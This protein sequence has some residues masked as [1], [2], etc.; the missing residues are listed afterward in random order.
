M[1]RQRQQAP[2]GSP[3]HYERHRPEQTA[4][5]LLVPLTAQPELVTALLTLVQRV[6]T[7]RLLHP[8]VWDWLH[9]S[10]PGI[11]LVD[12]RR[13]CNVKNVRMV[14]TM[15]AL[16]A[17]SFAQAATS[18]FDTGT[19]GWTAVGD[20]AAPVTWSATGGNPGGH[21]FI[22]DQVIGGVTYFDA[23]ID[24]RGDK[25]AAFGTNLTFDLMQVY[26]GGSNQ[27]DD[28]DVVIEGGGLAI[29]YDT[30][31]N[32]PNGAWASYAVPLSAG[33]WRLNSLSGAVATNQQ[34]LTVLS[35]VTLLRIRAEFQTGA[36]TGRLDNVSLVPEPGSALLL[37]GGLAA[38]LCLRRARRSE[39]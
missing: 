10:R 14:S 11:T 7:P 9:P 39:R 4:L 30:S 38:L 15:A 23:P 28:R 17:C 22:P 26:P 13:N 36:D 32:P 3:V 27:F 18:R 34:I 29:A 24:F 33:G 1:G 8:A 31:P 16:A 6:V 19:E 21:V 2:N 20:F 12:Q 25:S 35:S 37:A 5:Y